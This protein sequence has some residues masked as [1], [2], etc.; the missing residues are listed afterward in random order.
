M[1]ITEFL[2]AR[3]AEDEAAANEQDGAEYHTDGA[4]PD[5]M[6]ARVLAECAAKRAIIE[7]HP[8]GNAAYKDAAGAYLPMFRGYC[9]TCSD[10]EVEPWPCPTL[11]AIAAVYAD[12]PDYRQEWA[13]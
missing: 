10:H 8:D 5:G 13:L 9:A 12:H 2:I 4:W 7:A 11:R 1:T 3:I 6:A